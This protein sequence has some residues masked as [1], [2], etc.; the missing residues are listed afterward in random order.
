MLI[1]QCAVHKTLFIVKELSLCLEVE[2]QS[3]NAK[4]LKLQVLA[5]GFSYAFANRL[6]LINNY[7]AHSKRNCIFKVKVILSG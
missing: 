3:P 6:T 1:Y 4:S 2:C 7:V 5:I